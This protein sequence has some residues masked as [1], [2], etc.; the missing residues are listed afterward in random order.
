MDAWNKCTGV[1]NADALKGK[2]CFV[3]LDLSST[4]D[5]AALVLYFPE[6][7]QVLAWMWCPYDEAIT[8]DRGKRIPYLQW[9]HEGFLTLTEGNTIDHTA[10]LKEVTRVVAEYHVVQLAYD[11]WGAEWLQTKMLEA[12]YELE[13]VPFGQGYASMSLPAKELERLVLARELQHG[14]NPVLRWMASNVAVEADGLN[15]KPS[16]K[17]SYE[18]IDGIVALTMAIGVA[19]TGP[20]GPKHSVYDERGLLV[21][22]GGS[23][24]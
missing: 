3:G 8:R 20:Q 17:H 11:R 1:V 15:I 13:I 5:I 19:M 2:C 22:G 12:D 4:R 16:K 10:I 9:A 6:G 18:K 24:D 21:L 7:H 23:D 14:N